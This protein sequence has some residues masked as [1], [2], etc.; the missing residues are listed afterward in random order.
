MYIYL[1]T[2]CT[3]TYIS[4]IYVY[5]IYEFETIGKHAATLGAAGQE[6]QVFLKTYR[7]EASF[8]TLKELNRHLNQLTP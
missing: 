2:I 5:I 3:Y 6:K 4:Y 8:P 7:I 1:Y